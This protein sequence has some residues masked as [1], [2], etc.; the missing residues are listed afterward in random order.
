[1]TP[2]EYG[3]SV[4]PDAVKF[5]VEPFPLSVVKV[6]VVAPLST[7]EVPH[8]NEIAETEVRF[9]LIRPFKVAVDPVKE[10]T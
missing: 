7:L 9:G 3:D 1:M 2:V 8:A 6:T 5:I 4:A 10:E